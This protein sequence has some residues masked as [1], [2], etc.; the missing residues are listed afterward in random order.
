MLNLAA[1][2]AYYGSFVMFAV[3]GVVLFFCTKWIVEAWLCNRRA[4]AWLK[5]LNGYPQSSERACFKASRY[6]K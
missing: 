1:D 3:A 4:K 6:C 5:R 2:L